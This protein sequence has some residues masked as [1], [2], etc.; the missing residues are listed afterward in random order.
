MSND[1]DTPS[2]LESWAIENGCV[3][4]SV[5][6]SPHPTYGGLG[7]FNVASTSEHCDANRTGVFIPNSLIISIESI[8]EVAGESVALADVLNALP[9]TP[10]LEPLLTVFLLYQVSLNRAASP[11][12]WSTY[13]DHLPEKSLLPITWNDSE[14]LVLEQSSTSISSAVLAKLTS[15]R[16]IY[17]NL[18]QVEGWFQAISL[19]DYLLAESW[20]SSRTI[21]HPHTNKPILV[22]ILDMANHSPIRN[23][24]WEVTDHGIEVRREPVDIAEGKEI[25][26]SYDID[27]GTGER[28]YR[29]G[30]MEDPCPSALSKEVILLTP[31]LPPSAFKI[32]LHALR[33]SFQ[34]LSFL[35]YDNWYDC[36]FH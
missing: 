6:V 15:L 9:A 4:D 27:R 30:F 10:S 8:S 5:K 11:G 18:R 14:L 3:F 35:T 19:Q 28:L 7:L 20:V 31:S 1:V 12:N 23:A 24:A 13:I 17:K 22:P 34:D 29:Y 36:R 16:S 21:E 26:I 33:D 25:T 32:S 2:A